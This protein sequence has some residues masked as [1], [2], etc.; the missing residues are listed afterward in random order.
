MK[1]VINTKHVIPVE[2]GKLKYEISTADENIQRL[3][4]DLDACQR[5]LSGLQVATIEQAKEGLTEIFDITLGEGTGQEIY[6]EYPS[7]IT[8][9]DIA[10]QLLEAWAQEVNGLINNNNQEAI[11]KE[12]VKKKK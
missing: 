10:R 5:K 7:V 2:I 4:K 1:I 8:L 11:M 12:Y 9:A 3:A 6:K